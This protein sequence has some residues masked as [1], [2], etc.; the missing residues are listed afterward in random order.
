M[1]TLLITARNF[2]IISILTLLAVAS[3]HG[4][5]GIILSANVPFGFEAG[6]TSFPA[7]AYQ[8]KLTPGEQTFVIS[9]AKGGETKLPIIARL[10]GPSLFKDTGLVFDA[11]EGHH[12]LSELW[13]P[14]EGGVLVN[15]SPKQH[16]HEMVIAVVSGAQATMSGKEVFDHTCA[17]CHGLRGNGNPAADKFFQTPIPRLDSAQVQAKSNQELRDIITQGKR[18]M[19]PVRMGQGSVQHLL[20]PGSVDAVI[21]Y[22]RTLK[23]P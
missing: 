8:F 20:D 18:N 23:Q 2:T 6:G 14:G 7:G 19:D 11:F 22:V 5:T 10:G 15:A 9:G 16:A 4:Q 12:V 1:K 21:K 13:I 3:A 17:R